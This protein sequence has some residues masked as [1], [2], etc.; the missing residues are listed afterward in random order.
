M[1]LKKLLTCFFYLG[2]RRGKRILILTLIQILL[3]LSLIGGQTSENS[4]KEQTVI[5]E[6]EIVFGSV[7]GI[8]LKLDLARPG[9]GKGP[10]PALVFIHGGRLVQG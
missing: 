3:V 7:D 5:R 10:Y 9:K 8:D 1:K 6:T 2:I 4:S